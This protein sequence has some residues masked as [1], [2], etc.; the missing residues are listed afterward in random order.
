[1]AGK[2]NKKFLIIFSS[3]IVGLAVVVGG[4]GMYVWMGRADRLMSMGE[5]SRE[6]A[7]A[8]LER[9]EQQRAELAEARS[10]GETQRVESLT[11]SLADLTKEADEA[12]R[13]GENRVGRIVSRDPGNTEAR[14][15]WLWFMNRLKPED[16]QIYQKKF[17]E[18]VEGLRQNAEQ[19]MTNLD[20]QHRYLSFVLHATRAGAIPPGAGRRLNPF[21]LS[22]HVDRFDAQTQS[23]RIE[24]WEALRGY[25]A[26]GRLAEARQE[27]AR[28]RDASEKLL[29]LVNGARDDIDAVVEASG[30]K[31][32]RSELIQAIAEHFALRNEIF[33]ITGATGASAEFV[34]E[35][36]ERLNALAQRGEGDPVAQLL[37]HIMYYSNSIR[38]TIGEPPFVADGRATEALVNHRARFAEIL[39]TIEDMPDDRALASWFELSQYLQE[40]E[41]MATN[42]FGY[43]QTRGFLNRIWEAD[44]QGVVVPLRLAE[45]T[46]TA[47]RVGSGIDDFADALA[48]LDRVESLPKL[49][50]GIDGIRQL[51]LRTELPAMRSSITLD[52]WRVAALL[53]DSESTPKHAAALAEFSKALATMVSEENRD[54]LL[55]QAREAFVNGDFTRAASLIDS[56]LARG[57]QPSAQIN[58]MRGRMALARG[59]TTIAVRYLEPLVELPGT[60]RRSYRLDLAQAYEADRR[61]RDALTQYEAVQR[62]I[63]AGSS[64]GID[65]KIASLRA[66]LGEGQVD[67]PVRQALIEASLALQGEGINPGNPT[68][69]IAILED[70]L[71]AHG[72]NTELYERIAEI[73]LETGDTPGAI[74]ALERLIASGS[75]EPRHDE[76]LQRL[77]DGDVNQIALSRIDELDI[78][79]NQKRLRR[80]SLYRAL[81]QVDRAK[82][83][84]EAILADEPDNTLA[85]E[86]MFQIAV[87]GSDIASAERF[88]QRARELNIDNVEGAYFRGIVASMRND[89]ATALGLLQRAVDRQPDNIPF[90]RAFASEQALAGRTSEAVATYE[91]AIEL[92]ANDEGVLFDYVSLLQRLGREPRALQ[93]LRAAEISV[94]RSNRLRSMRL[95]LEARIGDRAAALAAREAI[96]AQNPRDAQ[97]AAALIGMYNEFGQWSSARRL[98]DSLRA[99]DDRLVFV[100]LDAEWHALQNDEQS[101]QRVINEYL[102][103]AYAEGR[104]SEAPQ[105]FMALGEYFSRRGQFERAESEFERAASMS[106]DDDTRALRM[107]AD[108]RRRLGQ[109]AKA[110][111]AFEQII[112]RQGANPD[113]SIRMELTQSLLRAGQIDE[114]EQVIASLRE[115]EAFDYKVTILRARIA[116]ARE[117]LPGARAAFDEALK[118]FPDASDLWASRA[119]LSYRQGLLR[120]SQQLIRDAI[121]DIDEGIRRDPTRV[122]LH[123]F[124]A[125]ASLE[126]GLNAEAAS[127]FREAV[128]V[129]RGARA[130]T[131]EAVARMLRVERFG[132]AAEFAE[133]AVT[134]N[135][136]DGD[137]AYDIGQTF[138]FAGRHDQATRYFRFAWERSPDART[139]LAYAEALLAQT[140]PRTPAA[141]SVFTDLGSSVVESDWQLLMAR[142]MMFRA[143][144]RQDPAAQDALRSFELAS[145]LRQGP[146]R[147]LSYLER[148][149][150]LEADRMAFLDILAR[151]AAWKPWSDL[152]RARIVSNDSARE[153][154]AM[155]ILRTLVGSENA[156]VQR[157]A[158]LQLAD[159]LVRASNFAEAETVLR[160]AVSK[161]PQDA[162]YLS[163][164]AYVLARSEGDADEAMTLAR[165]A[166]QIA[167]DS[168]EPYN[169]LGWAHW[170]KGNLIE[171]QAHLARAHEMVRQVPRSGRIGIVFALASVHAENGDGANARGFLRLVDSYIEE[172]DELSPPDKALEDALRAKIDSLG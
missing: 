114:A 140:P 171:A 144:G 34:R 100:I 109:H 102:Q 65:A 53:A 2:V 40:A 127:A 58:W 134:Q 87:A 86:Q 92:R 32:V 78:P 25:R 17:A 41:P 110:A 90:L 123:R 56:A 12:V 157:L 112:A 39:A 125:L 152:F 88:A 120:G 135:P 28:S 61:L 44:P 29:N 129:A 143:Q 71:Q 35:E 52:R 79:I 137:L 117:D 49:P 93:V 169:A 121:R 96:L 153:G 45:L 146:Q 106:P 168:P 148:R 118:T 133:A 23:M 116:E 111:E 151:R 11:R 74:E 22:Q 69:A 163:G 14:D 46:Q 80:A 132:D 101:G 103:K 97:N 122:E 159:L 51:T 170:R 162:G 150:P 33:R 115:R 1:M 60:A 172:G 154:E 47:G 15:L 104:E 70:A 89:R 57:A 164:L 165:S 8:L 20:A 38:Q 9:V 167:P 13:I 113:P 126:L 94:S 138:A 158:S 145:P 72:S 75:G 50:I 161:N 42:S 83:E 99:E 31:P 37:L 18:L 5:E 59:N 139:G 27:Y 119:E 55:C 73:R 77:R 95:D 36:V 147:W 3:I 6:Q 136:T 7:S 64:S 62:E 141:Q 30:D 68:M 128:R 156:E 149:A 98:L 19:R 130:V 81:R 21:E 76:F 63:G 142:A 131:L 107:L 43:E 16:D 160:Q 26:L 67:D 24:G 48:I 66:S 54:L 155:S 84:L 10:S 108:V 124:K 82:A 91:R 166:T 4:V 105:I 85:I